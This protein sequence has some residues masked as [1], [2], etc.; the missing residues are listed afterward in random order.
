MKL[1]ASEKLPLPVQK[2]RLIGAH[3]ARIAFALREIPCMDFQRQRRTG[4]GTNAGYRGYSLEV[5]FE[6]TISLP[7]GFG[8]GAHFGLGLFV[9]VEP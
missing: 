6:N 2:V 9:P 1:L 3:G 4:E 5:E 8:Y 7:F